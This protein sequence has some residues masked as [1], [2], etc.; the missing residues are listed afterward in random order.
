MRIAEAEAEAV[1][2][3]GS[4]SGLRQRK[5]QAVAAAAAAAEAAAAV[6]A[7]AAAV[8]AAEAEAVAAAEAAAV[9]AAAAAAEAA[10]VA[11]AEA[12]AV[13]AAEAEA[14]AAAEAAAEA[15][16]A[17][18]AAAEAEAVAAAEEAAEAAAE[19]VAAAEAEAE[20]EAEAAA[21]AAAAAAA[22][23]EAVAA[24]VAAAEVEATASLAAAKVAAIDAEMLSGAATEISLNADA[25]GGNVENENSSIISGTL[26]YDSEEN[27]QRTQKLDLLEDQ[28]PSVQISDA[29]TDPKLSETLA[30]LEDDEPIRLED[31]DDAGVHD[32]QQDLVVLDE[33]LVDGVS[34]HGAS[35]NF[36]EDE[37]AVAV[38]SLEKL[39]TEVDSSIDPSLTEEAQVLAKIEFLLGRVEEEFRRNALALATETALFLTDL[40]SGDIDGEFRIA[41]RSD[42][43]QG[44]YKAY[45]GDSTQVPMLTLPLHEIELHQLD[46][47][48]AFLLSRIDGSMSVED[49][50]DVCGM[51][52]LEALQLLSGL[53]MRG[54]LELR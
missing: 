34:E 32:D 14:V 30:S 54:V 33:I 1:A 50:L 52:R 31:L 45:L 29:L 16:A 17:A 38:S 39:Q 44:V 24:A 25:D 41:E 4:G 47:R 12:E 23:A 42:L 10:A 7:E 6:A 5:R 3:S 21:E 43:L 2:V 18:E 37:T 15:V 36:H 35:G 27:E 22:E 13:A 20:A 51:S 9:A 19:A 53:V 49:I 8:A 46:N 48:A 40:A 11:A 28:V 26:T